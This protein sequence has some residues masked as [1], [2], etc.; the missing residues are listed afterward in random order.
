MPSPSLHGW[1]H[2]D[3]NLLMLPAHFHG[4][5]SDPSPRGQLRIIDV[6]STPK[7]YAL[8]LEALHPGVGFAALQ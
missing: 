4:L 8:A 3:Q 6:A 7:Q 1:I 5:G 2:D